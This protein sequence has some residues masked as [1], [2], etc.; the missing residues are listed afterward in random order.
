MK[1]N[2]AYSILGVKNLATGEKYVVLRNPLGVPFTG[3]SNN[4]VLLNA[5]WNITDH[6]CDPRTGDD[7]GLGG[8]CNLLQEVNGYQNAFALRAGWFA[9][10]FGGYKYAWGLP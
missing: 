5:P 6:F 8:F 1:R 9:K 7:L 10:Y 3:Q 4:N 2:H